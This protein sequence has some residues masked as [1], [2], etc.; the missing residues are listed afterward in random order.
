MQPLPYPCR[1]LKLPFSFDVSRI[2]AELDALVGARWIKHMNTGDYEGGWSCLALRSV[3]GQ[4]DNIQALDGAEFRDTQALGQCPYLREVLDTFACEKTS[5][6][7]MA[8][9]AGAIIKPHRDPGGAFEDG[10]ARLHIPLQT[11]PDVAFCI[12][13]D[14]VHFSRADTWYLNAGCTHAVYNRSAQTRIHLMLDCPVNPWLQQVFDSSG[15]VPRAPSP[16]G[17]PVIDDDNVLDIISHLRMGGSPAGLD[18]A[19][20]LECIYRAR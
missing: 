3:E 19:Q 13:D 12:E 17:D 15:F 20:R 14:E 2:E 1:Y 10:L 9:E 11:H 18:L 7:L 16:Y 6:R 8:L 4:A 5:V